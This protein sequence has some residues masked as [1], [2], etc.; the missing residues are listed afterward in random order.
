MYR[1]LRNVLAWVT[2]RQVFPEEGG[3]CVIKSGKDEATLEGP[4]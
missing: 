4:Y 1:K 2:D 3:R